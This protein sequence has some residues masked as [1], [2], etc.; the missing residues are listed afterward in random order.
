MNFL[1]ILTLITLLVT[2]IKSEIIIENIN[3]Q[4][5]Y[6]KI[7]L[8]KVDIVKDFAHIAHRI[9]ITKIEEVLNFVEINILKLKEVNF[10][11]DIFSEI[12]TIKSE[13]KSVTNHRQKR[14]LFDIGGNVLK[15]LFGTMDESDRKNIEEMLTINKENNHELIINVNKQ[16]EINNKFRK[17]LNA[18]ET[19]FN[20]MLKNN[21]VNVK[22][23]SVTYVHRLIILEIR[24]KLNKIKQA[25][26]KI[27]NNILSSK[28][29]VMVGSMLNTEEI[30]RFKIDFNKLKNIKISTA[31]FKD[32]I[33]F[34]I[35]IPNNILKLNK[36]FVTN[37]PNSKQ[38]MINIKDN[39]VIMY[40]N[41]EYKYEDKELRNLKYYKNCLYYTNCTK[42][43]N[44]ESNNV[45]ELEQGK[46]LIK[47]GNIEIKT[48]CNEKTKMKIRNNVL[49]NYENCK[50]NIENKTYINLI[51]VE[52]RSTYLDNMEL[53]T[54]LANISEYKEIKLEEIENIDYIHE[55]FYDIQRH[56]YISYFMQTFIILSIITLVIFICKNKLHNICSR[57]SNN[58]KEGGVTLEPLDLPTTITTAANSTDPLCLSSI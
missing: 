55:K 12:E 47:N 33:I 7:K 30:N 37:L 9:N 45:I 53:Y 54:N 31:L 27:Q 23:E 52:E 15:F 58:F 24:E 43:I 3:N 26:E 14:S 49:I 8:N 44:K 20:E 10:P 5:G 32:E 48:N 42:I 56:S 17:T 21:F 22:K 16:I 57:S 28:L 18:I 38:E 50:I 4:E 46:L 39:Y 1:S 25:I 36:Y 51:N 40:E 13:I 34:V 41:K 11:T 6:V 2:K 35:S 19:E 29:N